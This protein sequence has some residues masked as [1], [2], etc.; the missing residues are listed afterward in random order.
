MRVV[1]EIVPSVPLQSRHR[2]FR[3]TLFL[4][5]LTSSSSLDR[6]R[7]EDSTRIESASTRTQGEW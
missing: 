3:H 4:V 5:Y 7:G 1:L 6:R 2:P